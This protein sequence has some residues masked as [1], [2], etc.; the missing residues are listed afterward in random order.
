MESTEALIN[1]HLAIWSETDR[2]K[3][4]QSIEEVYSDTCEILDPF[5][6]DI[7]RGRDALMNLI[8]GVQAKFP[9]FVFTKNQL[10]EHHNIIKLSWSYGPEGNPNVVTGDDFFIR[11]GKYIQFL[12]IFINKPE[13]APSS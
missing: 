11:D 9:G 13:T 2:Q 1:M 5:Y 12:Y 10:D 6:P 7:F 8:D 3:R 4:K